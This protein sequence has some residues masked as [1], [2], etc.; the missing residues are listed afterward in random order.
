MR[1]FVPILYVWGGGGVAVGITLDTVWLFVTGVI[2]I[3]AAVV[4]EE[5]AAP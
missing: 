2:F 3:V 4:I 1:G 5:F